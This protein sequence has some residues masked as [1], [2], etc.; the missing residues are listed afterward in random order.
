MASSLLPVILLVV[1]AST[2]ALQTSIPDIVVPVAMIIC[3]FKGHELPVGASVRLSN[4]GQGTQYRSNAK[5]PP[6]STTAGAYRS[7]RALASEKQLIFASPGR[8]CPVCITCCSRYR[9]GLLNELV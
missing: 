2:A 7:C 3:R 8:Y 5:R 6:N 4:L 9:L 1:S